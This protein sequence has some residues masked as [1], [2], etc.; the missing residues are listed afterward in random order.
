MNP[1]DKSLKQ[2]MPQSNVEFPFRPEEEEAAQVPVPQFEQQ[3]TPAALDASI[4]DQFAVPREAGYSA[5]RISIPT[6]DTEF[7]EQQQAKFQT[8]LEDLKQ[9]Y[10]TNR[11]EASKRQMYQEMI[12][13]LGNNI[14]NIVGG[15]QAMN[16]KAAVSAPKTAPINVKDQ[17][18][19]VDASFN[20]N[21]DNLL[22]QY[23]D[24]Q[25]QRLSPKD[26]LYAEIAQA[27]LIQG[28]NRLNANI[29]NTDRN[30]GIRVGTTK[31]NEQGKNE[32]SDKQTGE[33]TD[34]ETTLGEINKITNQADKFKDM[35]GPNRETYE[36]AKEGRLG[37]MLPGVNED[38][39]KFRSDAKALQGQYQK[40]ISGLTLSDAERTELKSYIPNVGMPY[41]SFKSNAEAFERRVR[42]IQKKK[43][44]AI[45][46]FQGKNTEGYEQPVGL[47][48]DQ[49]KALNWAQK[50]PTDPRSAAILKKLGM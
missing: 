29:E 45:K 36:S 27:N 22:K 37:F 39:V 2:M 46:K 28:A 31:L 30:A 16:T 18:A 21:Y 41:E 3:V 38:Y 14:G 42:E 43:K 15:A 7:Y 32:L 44:G 50:N 11:G 20:K 8:D 48:P 24:L 13:A 33:L 49:Q 17:V 47:S 19:A 12:A 25:G 23:K 34:I 5:P 4:L 26:K 6:E 35:L 40:I 1:F 9:N 10:D